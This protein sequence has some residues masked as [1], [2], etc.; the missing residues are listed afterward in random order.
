MSSSLPKL[1]RPVGG[2]GGR[3]ACDLHDLATLRARRRV[4]QQLF[5]EKVLAQVNLASIVMG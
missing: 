3:S 2:P 1:D 4:E 5:Q